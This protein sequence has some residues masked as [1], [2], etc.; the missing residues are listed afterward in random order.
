M[1]QRLAVRK[2]PMTDYKIALLHMRLDEKLTEMNEILFAMTF[3]YNNGNM[4][5]EEK[6]DKINKLVLRLE[7]IQYDE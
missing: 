4:A 5:L 6:K 1:S 2:R 3:I 7:K